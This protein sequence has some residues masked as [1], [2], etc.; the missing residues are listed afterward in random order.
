MIVHVPLNASVPPLKEIV[1]GAVTVSV[2]PLQAET[3]EEE[4]VSPAGR[5][6]EKETP[7]R[8]VPVLGFVNK[9]DSVLVLPVP[10]EFGV[11]LFDRFGTVGRGQPV[12]TML[13]RYTVDVAFALFLVSAWMVNLVV[14]LPVEAAVA[15]APVCHEPFDV[16]IVVADE[17]APPSALE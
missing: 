3:V 16:T 4:T 6:S 10:M 12:I 11:K 7:V 9:N 14:L 17:K 5:T 1:L 2:P 13:S 15:V 8:D